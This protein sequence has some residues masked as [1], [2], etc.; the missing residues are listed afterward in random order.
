MS[1]TLSAMREF[2]FLDDK[3]NASGLS[4]SEEF[5]WRE[6]GEV[7]KELLHCHTPGQEASQ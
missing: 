6:L 2:R 7:V 4:D 5:R 1:D 3:R